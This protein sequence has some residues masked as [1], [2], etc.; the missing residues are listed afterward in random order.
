MYGNLVLGQVYIEKSLMLKFCT[1]DKTIYI[2]FK[3]KLN[4]Y[5]NTFV[6]IY[7]LIICVSYFQVSGAN[8]SVYNIYAQ[9]WTNLGLTLRKYSFPEFV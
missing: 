9:W 3:L 8:I 7:V 2:V 1:R 4:K 5:T 6:T